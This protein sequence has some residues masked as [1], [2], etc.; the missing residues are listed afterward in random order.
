MAEEAVIFP[1]QSLFMVDRGWQRRKKK[2]GAKDSPFTEHELD[3]QASRVPEITITVAKGSGDTRS[4]SPPETKNEQ[5]QARSNSQQS[6][7]IQFMTYEPQK[8]NRRRQQGLKDRKQAKQSDKGRTSCPSDAVGH[9]AIQKDVFTLKQSLPGT[10]TALFPVVD[11][12]VGCFQEY[13]SYCKVSHA[14][15]RIP[16]AHTY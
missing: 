15:Q 10:A 14:G 4:T 7:S 8:L 13:L 16:N 2:G 11:P 12:E 6:G 1:P 3:L 5:A 9:A